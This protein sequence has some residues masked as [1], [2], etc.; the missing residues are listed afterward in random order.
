MSKEINKIVPSFL[1]DMCFF[2]INH[3]QFKDIS[4]DILFQLTKKFK[5][6]INDEKNIFINDNFFEFESKLFKNSNTALFYL[7]TEQKI[8]NTHNE[9]REKIKEKYYWFFV[10]EKFFQ[11]NRTFY[12]VKIDIK[13]KSQKR[14]SNRLLCVLLKIKNTQ[15]N[16]TINVLYLLF[17]IDYDNFHEK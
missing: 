3:K 1:I 9:Y 2:D 13:N 6:V 11:E 5:N 14:R 15:I 8:S 7:G 16:N 17:P 10:E 4:R 12:T